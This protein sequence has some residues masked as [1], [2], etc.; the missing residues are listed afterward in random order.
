MH[1]CG[2]ITQMYSLYYPTFAFCCILV[3]LPSLPITISHSMYIYIHSFGR[4]FCPTQHTNE[5]QPKKYSGLRRNLLSYQDSF[6]RERQIEKDHIRYRRA[7]PKNNFWR[8]RGTNSSSMS[9]S[10]TRGP[11]K[12]AVWT[13]SFFL[14]VTVRLVLVNLHISEQEQYVFV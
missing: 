4:C 13:E 2:L 1:L 8:H 6:E 12:G 3:L 11:H 9:H 5:I 14:A 7:R 10:T